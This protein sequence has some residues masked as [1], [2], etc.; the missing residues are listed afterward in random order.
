MTPLRFVAALLF[1]ALATPAAAA[2]LH[3]VCALDRPMIGYGEHVVVTALTDAPAGT[4]LQ[5]TWSADGGAVSQGSSPASAVWA[6]TS[7]TQA[8]FII[9]AR[10]VASGETADCTTRIAVTDSLTRGGN[11]TLVS[12]R[13]LLAPDAQ[14]AAG[15]G[16]YSYILFV[17]PQTDHDRD[18][19]ESILKSY[20]TLPDSETMETRFPD[21]FRPPR[22]NVTYVPIANP[23]PD[24]FDQRDDTDKFTWIRNHYD[25]YRAFAFLTQ[26]RALPGADTAM[27]GGTVWI[28]SSLHP[29]SSKKDP[30]PVL[31]ENLTAV[32]VRVI[33]DVM[34]YFADQTMQPRDYNP[35]ALGRLCL[36]L[37]IAI[38]QLAD[39]LQSV[40]AAF[41]VLGGV[42]GAE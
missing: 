7:Q 25:Y 39:G 17:A 22:L 36:D 3:A 42:G 4:P 32:P 9:R 37:R 16:L 13:S 24:D 19:L 5:V 10:V 30:R 31:P 33:P 35:Y 26:L 29:L 20:L 11:G 15:Y 8:V 2:P 1:P 18:L 6:P 28:V 40:T 41:K 12:T 27:L 34:R 38:A 14:E 21:T 23:L